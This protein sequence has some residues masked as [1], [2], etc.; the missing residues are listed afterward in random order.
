M[1][2]QEKWLVAIMAGVMAG[3]VTFAVARRVEYLRRAQRT[4][5][6]AVGA[7]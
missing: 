5:R 1:E 3:W 2:R 6:A 7:R 4:M